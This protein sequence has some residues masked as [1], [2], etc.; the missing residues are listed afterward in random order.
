VCRDVVVVDASIVDFP[1]H[2]MPPGDIRG[3]DIRTGEQ[4]WVFHAVPQAGE[5]GVDTWGEGSWAHTG[6]TN[7]WTIMSCENKYSHLPSVLPPTIIMVDIVP[8]ITRLLRVW[9][10]SRQNWGTVWH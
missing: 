2:E 3:F 5:L 7:V 10:R 9:W 4:R 1:R 8:A 6:N